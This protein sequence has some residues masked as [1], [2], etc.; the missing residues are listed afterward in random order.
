MKLVK[1]MVADREQ[2]A[3][4]PQQALSNCSAHG[5]PL[6]GVIRPENGDAVCSVHFLA[7]K[8]GWPNAT[9]VIEDCQT[10]LRLAR[11]AACS[12]TPNALSEESARLLFDA[13]KAHGVKFS[14]GQRADYKAASKGPGGQ[15]RPFMPL[16]MA[17]AMVE[18]SITA[19]AVEA[20]LTVSV[21][22]ADHSHEKERTNFDN[23]L[24]GLC[25]NISRA[26]A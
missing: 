10:L 24:K 13:A 14:D 4:A 1:K 7:S 25:L 26:A 5:C 2:S 20:A 19:K 17:G 12:G 18:A 16:R 9:A 15:P 22:T 23:L 8:T 21:S 11:Q 6:P 3:P